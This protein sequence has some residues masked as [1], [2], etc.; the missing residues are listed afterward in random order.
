[1][2]RLLEVCAVSVP[3][4][5]LTGVFFFWLL[6][7]S[8]PIG[9]TSMTQSEYDAY[10]ERYELHR[11]EITQNNKG[12]VDLAA[13]ALRSAIILN[14]AAAAAILA[15]VGRLW[16]GNENTC[17]VASLTNALALL[18]AGALTGAVATVFG[19]L[20]VELLAMNWSVFKVH[21]RNSASLL[22]SSSAMQMLAIMMV[23]QAY[24]FF[25]VALIDVI[26]TLQPT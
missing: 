25:T 6:H 26:H 22:F 2:Q 9:N 3:T 12:A 21:A 16:N 10:S 15:F 5:A 20:R 7:R 4:L 1:M 13:V 8:V 17:L 18:L 11:D 24:W 23:V 14:G 19:F